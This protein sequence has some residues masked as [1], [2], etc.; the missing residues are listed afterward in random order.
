MEET[1]QTEDEQ[2]QKIHYQV[3]QAGHNVESVE[4]TTAETPLQIAGEGIEVVGEVAGGIKQGLFGGSLG[5]T[6]Q[7]RKLLQMLKEKLLRKGKPDKEV[8]VR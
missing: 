4:P 5:K 6:T 1:A 2:R 3:Q 8:I 7:S